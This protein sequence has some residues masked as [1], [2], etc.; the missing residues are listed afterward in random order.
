NGSFSLTRMFGIIFTPFLV[1]ASRDSRSAVRANF[2][3]ELREA[4][5][6]SRENPLASS[7]KIRGL[8]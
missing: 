8:C 5:Q 4:E 6:Y 2:S 1:G 3:A 7:V